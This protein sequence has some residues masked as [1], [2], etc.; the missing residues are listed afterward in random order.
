MIYFEIVT[1][2]ALVIGL[3]AVNLTRPGVGVNLPMRP[4]VRHQPRRRRPGTRSSLHV[5]PESVIDAMA[6]G[7]VL[8][9]VVFSMFFGIALGMIGEKGA[10]G[11]RLVRSAR[12]NDVQVHEHRDATTRPS[13]SAARWL[14][15]RPRRAR[16]ARTTS[17]WLVGTLYLRAGRC[18]SWRL[19]ADRAH[20]AM[21][22]PASSSGGEG[23]GGDRVLH[24]LA[25]RRR[26]RARWRVLERLGVPRRIVAFVLPLGLQLQPRRL[27][28]LPVAR[29]DVRRAGRR[30]RS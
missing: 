23:A 5:V 19:P 26:C 8:Q 21:S 1:T 13:A 4:A 27:D 16:R 12:R 10:P 25:A 7:D 2:L 30:R 14:H 29:V 3:V 24:H 20:L 11:A 15:R 17:A 9:I 18:S 6:D 22:D 28:A